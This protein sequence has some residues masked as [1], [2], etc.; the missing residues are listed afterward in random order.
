MSGRGI[1]I[2][3]VVRCTGLL[4]VSFTVVVDKDKLSR[5]SLCV[6]VLPC[7]ACSL[8]MAAAVMPR[9][10]HAPN[11]SV[12]SF[13]LV[14]S[15]RDWFNSRLPLVLSQFH[16]IRNE[17]D[18]HCSSLMPVAYANCFPMRTRSCRRLTAGSP[19]RLRLLSPAVIRVSGRN[20]IFDNA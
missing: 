2:E 11:S 13:T 18:M 20:W 8:A 17:M 19:S 1:L 15:C 7:C 16:S 10:G 5:A 9:Q 3:L 6:K 12:V 4:S 14:M